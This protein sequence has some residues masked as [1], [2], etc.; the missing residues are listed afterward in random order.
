MHTSPVLILFLAY[1]D[2]HFGLLYY[3]AL[4]DAHSSDK[5]DVY[6]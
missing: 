3:L 4:M 1:Q 6:Q 2:H 5:I